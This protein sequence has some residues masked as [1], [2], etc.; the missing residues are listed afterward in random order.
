MNIISPMPTGNGAYILHKNLQ[1]AI[2]HYQVC[3]YSPWWTLLPITLPYLCHLKS[4]DLIHTTPDYGIFF[5]QKKIPHIVSFHS[6]VLDALTHQYSGRLQ[7][8]HHSTDLKWFTQASLKRATQVTSVSQF[9]ANLVRNDLAYHDDIRVIYN[10]V[11]I[12]RFVPRKR[13]AKTPIKVL[14]AGNLTRRKGAD[15][16]PDIAQKLDKDIHILYT[17]GL[18]AHKRFSVSPV[19]KA[20]GVIPYDNM[21]A[22]Y[23]EIDILLFPTVREGFGLVAAEA[24]ACGV[25]VVATNCS[26]LPEIV[27]DGKSGFL[28]ELGNAADF[29]EKI[30]I[31]AQ[32]PELRQKMGEFNRERVER[33][34]TE[35]RMIQEY[36]QL[37]EEVMD[38]HHE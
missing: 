5:N 14:F 8:L 16:L 28:C 22:L 31:L 18:R 27:V 19:L 21:P 7:R 15:L 6:Y 9:T 2:T 32:S 37:F 30:N 29:A 36:Q 20:L 26:S 17:S 33:L 38:T 13:S 35:E 34:F 25:P 12:H 24:M 10:G 23:Q 4:A 11:D 1:H 3:P